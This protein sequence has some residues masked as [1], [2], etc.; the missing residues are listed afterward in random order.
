MDWISKHSSKFVVH[1]KC[2]LICL[3]PPQCCMAPILE[4][5][6]TVDVIRF[7]N[8][9]NAEFILNP[10]DTSP[11]VARN[12]TQDHQNISKDEINKLKREIFI[13]FF[14]Y[15]LFV[16]LAMIIIKFVLKI[17]QEDQWIAIK[18]IFTFSH[19]HCVHIFSWISVVI[20]AFVIMW[21]FI[22]K[23]IGKK[24]LKLINKKW[25]MKICEIWTSWFFCYTSTGFYECSFF[26]FISDFVI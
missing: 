4:P 3:V 2:V 13:K 18:H 24:L 19:I 25:Q 20:L 7:E 12:L 26:N 15:V 22:G 1:E 8:T 11:L 23:C 6:Y 16:S 5:Y 17:L 21:I 9:T 10:L 14:L